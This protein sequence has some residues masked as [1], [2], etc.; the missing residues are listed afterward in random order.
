VQRS[1]GTTDRQKALE[2]HDH[3]KV[4][5]WRQ[6]RLGEKPTYT[7]D[8]AVLRF[9]AETT[10]KRSHA[11]DKQRLRWL[12]PHFEGVPLEGI[13]RDLLDETMAKRP[14]L[15]PATVNRYVAVVRSILRKACLEWDWIS[16]VPAF[17][18]RKEAQKRVRWIT[19]EEAARLIDALPSHLK[20]PAVFSLQTGLRQRNVFGLEWRQVDLQRRLAWIYVDQAKG[21]RDISVPLNPDAIA[22]LRRQLGNHDTHVFS[23]RGKPM[24][25]FDTRT[26]QK[27]LKIAG[28]DNFRWHD[29]RHTWA[30]WHVQAGT[31]LQELM[32]LGGWSSY[33]MVLRYAH[34]AD[35]HLHDAASRIGGTIQLRS[36]VVP[37]SGMKRGML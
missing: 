12:H 15:S 14:E 7:W 24:S 20:D 16:K 23:F 33:T 27:A 10:Y 13:T 4:Q 9:L 21:G 32:E 26:W 8:Q 18:I 31:T 37:I 5:L 25:C 19:Q 36:N 22:A 34:L 28:I 1:T 35:S 2:L 30:S 11:D 29:L 17:R 6:S 3:L